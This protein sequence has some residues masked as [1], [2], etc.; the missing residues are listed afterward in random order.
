MARRHVAFI[1]L[2]FVSTIL[3]HR[4]ITRIKIA[5]EINGGEKERKRA[6]VGVIDKQRETDTDRQT[7][8]DREKEKDTERE[9][10]KD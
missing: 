8:K 10:E 5:Y 1:V 7:E 9:R 3:L 2:I 4:K 6:C